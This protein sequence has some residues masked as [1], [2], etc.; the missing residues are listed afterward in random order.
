MRSSVEGEDSMRS[1]GIASCVQTQRGSE[2]RNRTE[3]IAER[4][5]A[6]GK[7]L[8]RFPGDIRPQV[9]ETA[10]RSASEGSN[11]PILIHMSARRWLVVLGS[12]VTSRQDSARYTRGIGSVT[13]ITGINLVKSTPVIGW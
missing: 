13:A 12:G 11:N 10:E 7:A 6:R 3:G 9:H 5:E 8:S 4:Y 2:S 1:G